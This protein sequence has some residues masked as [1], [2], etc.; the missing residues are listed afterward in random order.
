MMRILAPVTTE[1]PIFMHLTDLS[2]K[3]IRSAVDQCVAVGFEM[4]IFS[5]GSGLC[6][7]YVFHEQTLKNEGQK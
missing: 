5:F 6:M 3:G 7:F 2:S 4:I 1:N